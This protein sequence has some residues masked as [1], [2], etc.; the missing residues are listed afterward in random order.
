MSED[1][2]MFLT[3]RFGSVDTL[4]RARYWL[5]HHGFEVAQPNPEEHDETR[6]AL[7]LELSQVS[8]ALALIDSIERTDSRGWPGLH[9][10]PKTPHGHRARSR[11]RPEQPTSVTATTPIH[12]RAHHEHPSTDPT[13]C[14]ICEFMFSRPE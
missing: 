12:W 14:K 3:H 9:D 6:L 11:N 4:D 13:C 8:A 5:T 1:F 2:P 7:S 10:R